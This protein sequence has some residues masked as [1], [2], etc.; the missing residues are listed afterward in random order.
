MVCDTL[1]NVVIC[2]SITNQSVERGR[3]GGR[4][5]LLVCLLWFAEE[6]RGRIKGQREERNN[7]NKQRDEGEIRDIKSKRGGEK[8]VCV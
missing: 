8:R 3:R 5:R 6:E 1:A 7:I 4:S 2:K